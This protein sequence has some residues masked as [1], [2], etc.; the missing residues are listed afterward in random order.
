VSAVEARA[1]FRS[2]TDVIKK[3][4][5]RAPVRQR[6]DHNPSQ[7]TVSYWHPPIDSQDIAD[8]L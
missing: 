2:W 7:L 8:P 6:D 3:Q 4:I 1:D 5:A